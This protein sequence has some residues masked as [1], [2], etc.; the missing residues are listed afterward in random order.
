SAG[1]PGW[2]VVPK[3]ELSKKLLYEPEAQARDFG[4]VKAVASK[5]VPMACASPP[6]SR[7]PRWRWR[8]LAFFLIVAAGFLH[9]AYLACDCPLDLA[10]DEAHYWDWSRHLDWSYYSKG[11]VV[12][13]LIRGSCTLAGEWSRHLT[14]SE[15]LA[16]R[17]PAVLCGSLLLASLYVLSV[18]VYRRDRLATPVGS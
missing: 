18:Q 10:P 2:F 17:L 11:P 3:F 15:M 12:A 13:Y 1:D 6:P 8:T 14:G 5:D 4:L 9:L 16:V 7:P